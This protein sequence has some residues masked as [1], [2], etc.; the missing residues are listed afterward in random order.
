[1]DIRSMG[2]GMALAWLP[3]SWKDGT[4]RKIMLEM[5]NTFIR[6]PNCFGSGDC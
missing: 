3:V 4:F 5:S 6:I 2:Q 1:M